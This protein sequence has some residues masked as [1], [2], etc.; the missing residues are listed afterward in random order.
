MD[1]RN[2]L[3][4]RKPADQAIRDVITCIEENGRYLVEALAGSGKTSVCID[5]I[6]LNGFATPEKSITYISYTN[7]AVKEATERIK[8]VSHLNQNH[9]LIL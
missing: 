2:L 3:A 7:A 9:P 6:R 4:K 1:I 5:F 8:A